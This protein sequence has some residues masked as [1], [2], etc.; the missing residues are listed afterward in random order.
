MKG[1]AGIMMAMDGMMATKEVAAWI[2]QANADSAIVLVVDSPGGSVDGTEELAQVAAMD[3][4]SPTGKMYKEPIIGES[5]ESKKRRM[6]VFKNQQNI[7]RGLKRFY[8]G[9]NFV[10]AR[11]QENADR[12]ARSQ[13]WL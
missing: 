5:E 13:N 9:E 10:W 4:D 2:N 8:Y 1:K 6:E 7:K 12:K 3:Y 11:D